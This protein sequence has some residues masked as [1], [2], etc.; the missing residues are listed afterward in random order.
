MA[1]ERLTPVHANSKSSFSMGREKYALQTKYI[2]LSIELT[3]KKKR[4]TTFYIRMLNKWIREIRGSGVQQ[5]EMFLTIDDIE[6]LGFAS[7]AFPFRLRR[8]YRI[9]LEI[10][11][12]KEEN[13][14]RF[15]DSWRDNLN[16]ITVSNRGA[17]IRLKKIEDL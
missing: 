10:R 15:I 6:L 9:R 11:R 3:D 1:N 17:I 13:C 16:K 4:D 2:A 8:K 7:R 5:G 14:D 12:Y